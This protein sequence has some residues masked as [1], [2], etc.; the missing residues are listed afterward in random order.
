MVVDNRNSFLSILLQKA[1]EI[2]LRKECRN[3]NSIKIN[4]IASSK[5]ILK[6]NI[7]K[8]HLLAK[9][10]N[11][12]DLIFDEIELKAK[13]VN[14]SFKLKRAELLF[15]NEFIANFKIQL[16]QNS[17]KTILLSKSW[18]WIGTMISNEL[19]NSKLFKDI[20][21][22]NDKI[23][24]AGVN[25]NQ[26]EINLEE[27]NILSKNGKIYLENII[28]NKSISIPIEDK[29]FIEKIN[30]HENSIFIYA[31]SSINI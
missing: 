14:L 30:I 11:Y 22:L 7:K 28:S 13:E 6:G 3:I 12:K 23:Q 24:I 1:I 17:L 8:I 27:V 5:E 15:K 18:N 9:G 19:L 21:I 26:D 31:Y 25:N 4:I 29:V 16:S 2:L 10:I 20:K